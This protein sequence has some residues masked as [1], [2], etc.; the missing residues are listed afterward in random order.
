MANNN[1]TKEDLLALMKDVKNTFTDINAAIVDRGGENSV[2][3]WS[4]SGAVST[5][6]KGEFGYLDETIK[7]NGEYYYKATD[8]GYDGFYGVEINV[9]VSGGEGGYSYFDGSFDE[10]GLRDLGWTDD[11]IQ[12]FKSYAPHYAW[13]DEKYVVSD[14]NKEYNYKNYPQQN[15]LVSAMSN[16]TENASFYPYI[17]E[18]LVYINNAADVYGTNNFD[19]L[20]NTIGIPA[21]DTSLRT[22]F[23]NFFS[24]CRK[25]RF[26]PPINTKNGTDF[27]MMFFECREITSIPPIDTSNGTSFNNMFNGCISL[28]SIPLLDT[29]NGTNFSQMFST[30]NNLKSIPPLDTHNGTNFTSMF[31]NCSN[32]TSIPPLDTSNGTSFSQIFYGCSKLQRVESIDFSGA[33][34]AIVKTTFPTNNSTLTYLRLNG[35]L[36]V[37]ADFSYLRALDHDSY[38]SILDAARNTTN[39]DSK[40]LT[41]Y[42]RTIEDPDGLLAKYVGD[43]ENVGWQIVGLTLA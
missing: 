25:L 43:C 27:I 8:Y 7:D 12:Y 40:T 14:G 9:N 21:Y 17:P 23:Y 19:S 41:F 15:L 24:G 1:Y 5:I 6:P 36:N 39:T 33:T 30:C 18:H 37:S 20:S 38:A 4:L 13:E 42:S 10:Q 34:S 26:V 11:D 29:S 3:G 2:D 35:T 16:D 32:L 31:S 28:Q 22:S